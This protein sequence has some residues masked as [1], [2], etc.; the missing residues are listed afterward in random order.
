[1]S[2]TEPTFQLLMSPLKLEHAGLQPSSTE[3]E[4]AQKRYD[5]SLTADTFHVLMSPY[6]AAAEVGSAHHSSRAKSSA[7]R[8]LKTTEG[9]EGGKAGGDGGVEQL[10]QL[11]AQ[12]LIMYAWC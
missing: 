12:S 5:I 3:Y 9:A 1:M 4:Y 6:V 2:V 8:L 11:R 7:V 10:L